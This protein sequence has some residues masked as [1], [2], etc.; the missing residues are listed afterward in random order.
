MRVSQSLPWAI[1]APL[2]R[3][4][5]STHPIHQDSPEWLSLS[6]RANKDRQI[7]SSFK[8]T[9]WTHS[10][11]LTG[12]QVDYGTSA[13]KTLCAYHPSQGLLRTC[14]EPSA[15]FVCKISHPITYGTM[16][17]SCEFMNVKY[18][19]GEFA[20]HSL[21]GRLGRLQPSHN[22]Q[23]QQFLHTIHRQWPSL[24]LTHVS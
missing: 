17:S 2:A 18:A 20:E 22:L 19:G 14:L 5:P 3:A 11:V 4:A 13:Y 7:N 21:P 16:T 12:T 6:Y 10:H 9:L 15:S 24:A 8:H 23:T 1:I